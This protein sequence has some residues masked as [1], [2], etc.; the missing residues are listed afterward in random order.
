MKRWRKG[1][2]LTPRIRAGGYVAVTL[3]RK[4]IPIHHLVCESFNGTRPHGYQTNHKDGDKRNNAAQN[5]E[6]VTA[7][8]NRKHAM[9]TGL[10]KTNKGQRW[11]KL[12]REQVL[13][14]RKLKKGGMSGTKIAKKF[15]VS[16][17]TVARIIKKVTFKNYV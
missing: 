9:E 17:S 11:E 1:K 15:R 10:Q 14:I 13:E 12:D 7:G 3:F 2:I 5:L 6:W 8:Q 4:D 16:H